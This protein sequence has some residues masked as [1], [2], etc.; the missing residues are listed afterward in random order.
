MFFRK[1]SRDYFLNKGEQH[2]KKELSD[3]VDYVVN[4]QN[5]IELTNSDIL[6][7]N[8][9]SKESVPYKVKKYVSKNKENLLK[10]IAGIA[11]TIEENEYKSVERALEKI[12]F[13]KLDRKKIDNLLSAQKTLSLS[14]NS[15]KLTMDIFLNINKRLKEGIESSKNIDRDKHT[16][17]L[18]KNSILVYELT[19]F[20][21]NYIN[22]FGLNG[23][24]DME[25]IKAEVFA[26]I[27]Q[28]RN[29]ENLLHD[30]LRS[31]KDVSSDIKE[32]TLRA[33]EDR[34]EALNL[35]ERKWDEFNNKIESIRNGVSAV[36]HLI[37]D[38][39]VIQANAERQ[40]DVLQLIFTMQILESNLKL[41]QGIANIREIEL[42]PLT[43]QDAA[44]LLGL[45][46]QEISLDAIPLTCVQDKKK[47]NVS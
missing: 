17:E 47:A 35:I 7:N 8:I 20:I 26:D 24:N 9:L 13:T 14:F 27:E 38:L 3:Q 29:K 1:K 5:K 42:A 34:L 15:L 30:D 28:S 11:L 32:M 10:I 40:I 2:F 46:T 39:K 36:K 21:I 33:S 41:L 6:S 18:L 12:K 43:P 22:S 23:I 19:G 37:P 31:K 16:K 4:F 45:E 25:E 44:I